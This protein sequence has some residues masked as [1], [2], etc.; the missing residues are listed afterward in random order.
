LGWDN[1]ENQWR[2]ATFDDALTTTYMKDG[3]LMSETRYDAIA[4]LYNTN[5]VDLALEI[6]KRYGIT[7]IY[8]G[9]TERRDFAATGLEKFAALP[10]VCISGD[11]AVYAADSLGSTNASVSLK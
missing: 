2:G 3:V 1:H 7:Y 9:P 5:S 6:V 4:S 11:V 10:P 8:V